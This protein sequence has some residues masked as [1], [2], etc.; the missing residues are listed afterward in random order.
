MLNVRV[1]HG[2]DIYRLILC[3]LGIF[4]VL[5]DVQSLEII[6]SIPISHLFLYL[7]LVLVV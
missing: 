7:C 4:Q 3:D 1:R 6:E 2:T 5:S